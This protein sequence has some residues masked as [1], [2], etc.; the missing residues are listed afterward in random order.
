M[1]CVF[2]WLWFSY[3]TADGRAL[4]RPPLSVPITE[5]GMYYE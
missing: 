2:V 5:H 1:S 4:W 3:F